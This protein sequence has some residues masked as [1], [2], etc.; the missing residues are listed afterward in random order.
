MV[1]PRSC[2]RCGGA[3]V[4]SSNLYHDDDFCVNCGWRSL[5]L[6]DSVL[7]EFLKHHGDEQIEGY[8]PRNNIGT[9]KAP[10]T[11][12]ERRQRKIRNR[13]QS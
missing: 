3:L 9:R 1:S 12:Q 13:R 7:G 11:G 2:S 4:N 5:D 10:P 6:P 8:K